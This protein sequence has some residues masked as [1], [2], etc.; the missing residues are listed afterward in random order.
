MVHGFPIRFIVEVTN[1]E[2][3]PLQATTRSEVVCRWHQI[4]D[5]TKLT[6]ITERA[7]LTLSLYE[8]SKFKY[9]WR[10][11]F[12]LDITAGERGSIG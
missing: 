5:L 3:Y 2:A 6:L 4:S 9:T 8:Q 12:N 10:L 11:L 1:G 7:G